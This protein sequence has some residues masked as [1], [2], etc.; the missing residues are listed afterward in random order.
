MNN[1]PRLLA[2]LALAILMVSAGCSASCP[3]GQARLTGQERQYPITPKPYIDD[4]P[5]LEGG[6]PVSGS[7]SYY[8]GYYERGVGTR[9]DASRWSPD[10]LKAASF[11]HASNIYFHFDS[12]ALTQDARA[13][14]SQKAARIKA[15]P[16]L[17]VVIGGHSDERGSDEYNMRLGERRA[18]AAYNYLIQLGVPSRQLATQSF[19]KRFPVATGGGETSWSQNR[20]DEF[21]VSKP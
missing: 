10:E 19:G 6:R 9:F 3:P 11:I 5:P 13:V 2:I 15:F 21:L 16:Q 8:G 4:K 1:S 7:D 14:L 17:H 12:S 20:R 18:K